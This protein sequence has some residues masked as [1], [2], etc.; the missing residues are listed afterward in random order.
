MMIMS[1]NDA[2]GAGMLEAGRGDP[3]S[4]RGVARTGLGNDYYMSAYKKLQQQA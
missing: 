2:A 1:T 3:T 4:H